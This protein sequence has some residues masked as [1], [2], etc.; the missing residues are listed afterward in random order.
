MSA[1]NPLAPYDALLY[2]S[3]GGPERQ[4]DVMPFLRN[5]TAGRG[6]PDER[7]EEV[8]THY[9]ARGGRS[10][11][12]DENRAVLTR[13]EAELAARAVQVPVVWGN[14]F[15]DP[16][17]VEALRSAQ[18]AGAR[19]LLTVVTSA[20]P[21]YSGCRSYREDLAAA[22]A[23]LEASAAAAGAESLQIDVL[24]PY[25]QTRAF[26]EPMKTLTVAGLRDLCAQAGLTPEQVRILFVTHSI[27]EAMNAAS[28]PTEEPSTYITMHTTVC[29][30]LAAGVRAET[31]VAVPWQLVYCS[32]SGPP[33]QPWLEPDVNDAIAAIAADRDEHP[34][35]GGVGG[36]LIVPM[37]FVSDHMEVV[38]DLDEEA[39]AT[40][41]EHGLAAL[42][43]PTV[44]D[45]QRFVSG[46][47]DLL[48][49]RA[50]A[51]REAPATP[52]LRCPAGCCAGRSPAKPTVSDE[53]SPADAE[54]SPHSGESVAARGCR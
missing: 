54:I 47:V 18:E 20:F 31:G 15:F 5:V 26:V 14:K 28:G 40:A 23:E 33:T 25:G 12:N 6:I 51:E 21:S 7:L 30:E 35:E 42:R 9:R 37:G 2:L 44:R 52:G 43:V 24:R 13:L 48:L 32:R 16:Y 34:G 17:T 53:A 10:P 27:P 11:I 46:L 29:D 4:E 50:R 41:G 3:F 49:E 45:D 8:A 36:V 38:Y 19:R 22:R 1:Q 39:M